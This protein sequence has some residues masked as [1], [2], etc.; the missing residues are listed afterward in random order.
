MSGRQLGALLQTHGGKGEDDGGIR[1]AVVAGG[2][3]VGL[4]AVV[5]RATVVTSKV[6]A[7]WCTG[8]VMAAVVGDDGDGVGWQWGRGDGVGLVA[9][10][11]KA[12]MVTSRVMVWW[13]T[14]EVMETVVGDDDDGVGWQCGDGG[15]VETK[16]MLR[17]RR[18]LP[19]A[20][21]QNL[22]GAVPKEMEERENGEEVEMMEMKAVA[23][24]DMVERAV[25]MVWW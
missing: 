8:G 5:E 11:E 18:W 19:S 22:A 24:G 9:V 4:V 1:V 23:A 20:G 15:G 12:M 10:L 17:G 2:D 7:W 6:M 16:M 14:A 21:G 13:C 25:A 3:G